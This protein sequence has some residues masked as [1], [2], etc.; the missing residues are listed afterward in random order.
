VLAGLCASSGNFDF[1]AVRH[2]A[3]AN[4]DIGFNGNGKL[5]TPIGPNY[6]RVTAAA[7]QL[8]GKI[9]LAGY[10]S[11]STGNSVFC[12]ARYDGG[13]F[14]AQNCKLDI[15]GDNRLLPA[16]DSLIH[17][18]IALGFTGEA[19]VAGIAF[20]AGATRK[21]WA[22]IRTYLVTQCGLNLPEATTPDL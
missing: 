2:H 17:T 20:P 1:C 7:L 4:L 14:G 10:C 13:P 12:I 9:M 15:D 18:R 6:D 21:T 3:N 11:N 22:S 19:V 5:I 8:D 16:T